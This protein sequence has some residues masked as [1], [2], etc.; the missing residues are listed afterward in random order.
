MNQGCRGD[1]TPATLPQAP[2]SSHP[3]LP[4]FLSCFTLHEQRGEVIL[5]QVCHLWKLQMG[6][7]MDELLICNKELIKA[8]GGCRGSSQGKQFPF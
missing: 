6:T 8:A 7:G 5:L 3:P 4:Y 2:T 1:K